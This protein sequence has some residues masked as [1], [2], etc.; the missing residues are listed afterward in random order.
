MSDVTAARPFVKPDEAPATFVITIGDLQRDW[1]LS[2]EARERIMTECAARWG[3]SHEEL[4]TN[5]LTLRAGAGS[6]VPERKEREDTSD[7]S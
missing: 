6:S 1:T 7:G 3:W 5:I 2:L 4:V